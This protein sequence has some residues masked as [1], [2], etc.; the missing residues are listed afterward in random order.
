MIKEKKTL[1]MNTIFLYIL[2]ISRYIFPLL[3]F[4][5]LTRVLMP[6]NYGI[7]TFVNGIMVYFALIIDFGFLQS[8]T[9]DC[10]INRDDN[11][12]LNTIVSATTQA[13][14]LLGLIGLFIIL[15]SIF[16]LDVFNG[17]ELF[18]IL[19][20]ATIF[21]TIFNIDYLFRGIESMQI[22]T[23]RTIVGRIIYTALIFIFVG[24]PDDYIL[25]PII[26]FIGES[27]VLFWTWS[28]AISRISVKPH[29]VSLSKTI[30]TLKKSTEFF[31][32]RIAST[33][34]TSTNIVVLGLL[35]GNVQVAIFGVAN[36]LI[37]NIRSMFSPIADS[38][39]PYMVKNKDY[40]II[41]KVLYILMPLVVVA[42]TGLYFF[43]EP[44][45]LLMSGNE[46]MSAVP[47]F[48][49]FLPLILITLPLYL[50]GFP[51]LGAMNRMR[52]ANISVIMAAF[53]HLF[54]LFLLYF[55][56]NLNFISVVIL[57]TTTELFVLVYRTYCVYNEFRLNVYNNDV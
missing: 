21:L 52:D 4:P 29:L 40:T 12:K 45:I 32:S 8:A 35:Y 51:T 43:A 37:A 17:K 10:S 11:S 1:F 38:L 55:T 44:I 2:Q 42:T 19:S 36:T 39:Y 7:M 26:S 56:G 53:Y 54:G 9:N 16:F 6:E 33:A 50:F 47:I 14:F 18:T 24:S 25:I 3:T 31:L 57:T 5:Y 28:Y 13:K 48:R 15:L 23:K 41:K 30:E 46:Y 20:F 27:I 34:Y 22:I 49:A